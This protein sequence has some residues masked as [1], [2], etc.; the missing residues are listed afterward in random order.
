MKGQLSDPL[1]VIAHEHRWQE[2]L[3]DALERIAD[4]LPDNVD[5]MLVSTILPMLQQ[6]LDIH[7]RDEELGLFPLLLARAAPEDNFAG[8][9]EV[10]SREHAADEG[11][12]EEIIDELECLRTSE[13][14]G[15]P[16][17]VG[18]MLRGFFEGQR[19]HLAWEDAVVLPLARARL[20]AED[21]RELGRIMVENRRGQRPRVV[22]GE[23]VLFEFRLSNER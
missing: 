15:N 14:P 19:R 23:A 7:V 10:L 9:M 11:F 13:R 1:A 17:M 6:D 12:A 22:R 8:I 2:R 3:C 20:T 18:Y 21:L 16:D 5:R 4:D